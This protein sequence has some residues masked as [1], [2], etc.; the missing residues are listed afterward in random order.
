MPPHPLSQEPVRRYVSSRSKS[1][2]HKHKTN[3]AVNGG[4]FPGRPPMRSTSTLTVDEITKITQ[5]MNL[6]TSQSSVRPNL[7]HPETL[8]RSH[9]APVENTGPYK[10]NLPEKYTS[11]S[12]GSN[13]STSSSGSSSNYLD[14]IL[15]LPVNAPP[16]R[17][18]MTRGSHTV[19]QRRRVTFNESVQVFE[20]PKIFKDKTNQFNEIP[21]IQKIKVKKSRKIKRQATMA[22][23]DFIDCNATF[24]FPEQRPSR[25]S[26]ARRMTSFIKDRIKPSTI[27]TVYRSA[28]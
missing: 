11:H 3:H 20:V 28:K 24:Y 21:Q 26:S 17:Y 5:Q 22:N 15:S 19:P 23:K 13:N 4:P 14:H 7:A 9:S 25:R 8:F 1:T 10:E 12:I 27:P 6:E 16:S 2:N 18:H